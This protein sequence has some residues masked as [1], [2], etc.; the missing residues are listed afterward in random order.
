M[1]NIFLFPQCTF[2][3]RYSAEHTISFTPFPNVTQ[4]TVACNNKEQPKSVQPY[5]PLPMWWPKTTTDVVY[6]SKTS[7]CG[8]IFA[9]VWTFASG[10]SCPPLKKEDNFVDCSFTLG[11]RHCFTSPPL[12]LSPPNLTHIM[13]KPDLPR[14]R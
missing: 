12:R 2:G 10:S 6:D 9:P 13:Y 1:E 11:R 5:K 14:L 3:T 8:L 4:T 7:Q